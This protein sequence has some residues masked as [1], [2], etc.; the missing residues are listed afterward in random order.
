MKPQV[1]VELVPAHGCSR[2]V[3]CHRTLAKQALV[4]VH[5]PMHLVHWWVAM[6]QG[7]QSPLVLPLHAGVP[8]RL[9]WQ[10]HRGPLHVWLGLE[11]AI[12]S[13]VLPH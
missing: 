8:V 2:E 9:S 7:P 12:G 4:R 6:G 13:L 10:A 11:R 5:L 3:L 1:A